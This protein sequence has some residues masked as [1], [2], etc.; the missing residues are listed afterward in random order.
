MEIQ[1]PKKLTISGIEIMQYLS[2]DEKAMIANAIYLKKSGIAKTNF[3]QARTK[4]ANYMECM[5]Y[6]EL[7]S[8]T[9]RMVYIRR[10]LNYSFGT[11][12]DET[13]PYYTEGE[14]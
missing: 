3:N 10:A 9:D 13:H 2:A 5:N 6:K 14:K 1:V 12:M 8:E 4:F 11:A 7:Y